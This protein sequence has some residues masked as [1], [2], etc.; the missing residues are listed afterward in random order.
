MPNHYTPRLSKTR[1]LAALRCPKSLWLEYRAPELADPVDEVRQARFEQGHLVGALARE[2]YGGGV[3]VEEDHTQAAQAL[4]TTRELLARGVDCLYEGAFEYDGVFIRADILF[5]QDAA[6]WTLVEVKS[7]TSAKPEH[8]PDLAIQ[9]Y[10]SRGAGLP[11]TSAR[12]LHLNSSY[13]YA[14]G[15]YDLGELFMETDLSREVADLLPE[16]PGLLQSARRMLSGPAPE[17]ALG[18]RC[19]LPYACRFYGYC[20]KD[21]PDHPVT[22]LPG[23]SEELL[24]S[25][26]A[27]GYLSMREVP[28][29]Y[30]GLSARQRTACYL[31]RTGEVRFGP[32]LKEALGRLRGPLSFLDFETFGPALPLY[33][34]TR[35]YQAVPFQWSC[36]T[37]ADGLVHAE[38]LH[39]DASDPRPALAESLLKAV[40]GGGSVVVYTGFENRILE[41]LAVDLPHLAPGLRELQARLFDLE[42]VVREHVLHPDFHGRTSLKWVMPALVPDLSYSDLAIADGQTASLRW[43][44]AV[45]GGLA[46]S[47]REQVFAELRAYCATD[48]LA[49]VRLLEVLRAQ[50]G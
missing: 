39:T 37:Q 49:L 23:A 19:E 43:A 32:G 9:T 20:H 33:P 13:L 12:L 18:K 40:S 27:N 4:S 25:L 30:P 45:H 17:I 41:S 46:E 24:A 15:P 3:V 31:A 44:E 11:V 16:I 35:P 22:E 42:K 28:L 38:F 5:R 50:A 2:R 1:F 47:E 10:V 14:G 6:E 7:S 48:T 26:Q 34:G 36:H 21:L 29:D 8:L